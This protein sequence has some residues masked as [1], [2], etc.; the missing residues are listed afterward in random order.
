MCV[1]QLCCS[2]RRVDVL[3]GETFRAFQRGDEAGVRAV[4]RRYGSLVTSV[5]MQMLR[6]RDLAEEATQQ[7]FVQAWRASSALDA[8]RDIAPW[9]VTIA[10]RVAIDI[11]R[12]E[13][14]RQSTSLDEVDPS[15]D[16]L[17]S[18][19]PSETAA[20]EVAQVRLAIES[21]L[22]EDQEVVRMQHLQGYTQ[23]EIADRLGIPLGTVKSRS[24]RAHKTLAAGLRHLRVA[25]E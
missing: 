10:R 23:M 16:A 1:V 15:D 5:C 8:D 12:R 9:L 6:R 18:L 3:D 21:L 22:P 14:R 25:V 13:G 7:T 4:Y 20:W 19:P 17:V 11:A 2:V 24:F